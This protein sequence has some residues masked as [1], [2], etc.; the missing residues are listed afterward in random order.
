MRRQAQRARRKNADAAV[1]AMRALVRSLDEVTVVDDRGARY[2]L[3]SEGM[4]GKSR[5][6]G[7]PAEPCPLLGVTRN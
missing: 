4:S 7:E 1:T 3:R 2:A 5:R 6:S